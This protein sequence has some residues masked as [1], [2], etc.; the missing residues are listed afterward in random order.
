MFALLLAGSRNA[1]DKD[2]WSQIVKPGVH[3]Q[4]AMITVDT[5][6]Q[7]SCS[8]TGCSGR[9]SSTELGNGMMERLWYRNFP[10]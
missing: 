10:K 5:Q 9:S 4:Q 6:D 1:I 8:F 2:K 7:E 3:I